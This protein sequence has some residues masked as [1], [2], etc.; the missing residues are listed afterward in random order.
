[1]NILFLSR[2]SNN[3]NCGP[4]YSVPR[5]VAAQREYD[6]VFWL[7]ANSNYFEEWAEIGDIKTEKEYPSMRLKDLPEPFNHPD[8]V[9]VQE[10]YNFLG[11][12]LIRDIQKARIPYVVVPRCSLTCSAQQKKRLKKSV[13]NFLYFNSFLRKAAGI[14]YLTKQEKKESGEHWNSNG[15]VIPNGINIPQIKKEYNTGKIECTYIGRIDFYHKGLDLMLNAIIQLSDII[16]KANMHLNIYGWGSQDDIEKLNE[17]IKRCNKIVEFKGPVH[18]NEKEKVLLESDV[19]FL[20]SRFEGMPMGLL[21]AMSYGIPVMITK[22]TNMNPIVKKFNCGWYSD[23]SEIGIKKMIQAIIYERKSIPE[24]GKN[25]V[26]AAKL[27]DWSNI[28]RKMHEEL[29]KIVA[30]YRC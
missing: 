22:G 4:Y 28:A 1:M 3:N 12:P 19:F 24:K 10:Q 9:L 8:V 7:N 20:T 18:G 17:T 5:Q 2:L 6:N 14:Q 30:K 26:R 21:E 29:D 27:F 23:S 13:G 16:S 11:M 25:G 15:F